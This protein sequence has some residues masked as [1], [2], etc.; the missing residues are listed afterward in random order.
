MLPRWISLFYC[1]YIEDSIY[2]VVDDTSCG[3]KQEGKFVSVIL[4]TFYLSLYG[5]IVKDCSYIET[6]SD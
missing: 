6:I 2:H 4:S 3:R 5:Q 1:Y